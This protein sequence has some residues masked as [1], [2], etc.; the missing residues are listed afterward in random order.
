MMDG[1][2]TNR[3]DS[4]HPGSV[5][6]REKVQEQLDETGHEGTSDGSFPETHEEG[7]TG[8]PHPKRDDGR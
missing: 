6:P 8:Q 4:E 7:K 2:S 5:T 3:P 1:K